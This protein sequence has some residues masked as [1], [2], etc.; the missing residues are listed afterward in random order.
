[1]YA[2]ITVQ[3]AQVSTTSPSSDAL[4]RS[5][6]L[7]FTTLRTTVFHPLEIQFLTHLELVFETI[8]LSLQPSIEEKHGSSKAI[9][10]VAHKMLSI[11]HVILTRNEPYQGENR[12]LTEQKH[13]RLNRIANMA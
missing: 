8:Q 3:N 9:I 11:M 6:F 1:V 5:L 12:R 4:S 7:D 2:R 10:P 13:E